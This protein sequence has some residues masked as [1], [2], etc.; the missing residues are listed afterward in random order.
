MSDELKLVNVTELRIKQNYRQTY[1]ESFV[2]TLRN[3]MIANGFKMS[4]PITVYLEDGTYW[5]VDGNTRYTAASTI[6]EFKV[7]VVVTDKPSD[8][9]FKLDQ[10]SAN[11][12]RI[13]PDDISKAIGYTQ[14]LSAGAT[15]DQIVSATGH[16]KAYVERRMV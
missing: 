5:I 8:A 3:D 15:M 1:D 12:K 7:W 10:L 2:A 16:D 11:E 9:Q 13:D 14:A 4:F 6:P